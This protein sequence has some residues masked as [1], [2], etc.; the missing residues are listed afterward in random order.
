MRGSVDVREI[1]E[2]MHLHALPVIVDARLKFLQQ[3]ILKI[4]G[5]G[6]RIW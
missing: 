6:G 3:K 1:I 4:F 2:L 5:V